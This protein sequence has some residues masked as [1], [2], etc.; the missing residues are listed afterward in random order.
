M[1]SHQLLLWKNSPVIPVVPTGDS[2]P[3]EGWVGK[4]MVETGRKTEYEQRLEGDP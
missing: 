4:T 1:D 2:G 3:L